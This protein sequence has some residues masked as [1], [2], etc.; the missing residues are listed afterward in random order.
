MN[1]KYTEFLYPSA[2]PPNLP[3]SQHPAQGGRFVTI[4]E[5]VLIHGYH[6]ESIV[7]IQVHSW[8]C[9]FYGFGQ[10]Y[11]DMYPPSQYQIEYFPCSRKPLALPIYPSLSSTSWQPLIFF[12]PL[13]LPFPE[14]PI[15]GI[16]QNVAFSDW[17]PSL[18]N[19][20]LTFLHVFHG[21]LARFSK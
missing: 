7:Y 9:A 12:F 11:N 8:W 19:R 21:L 2:H 15:V 5:A 6:P 17:P 14:C 4:G 10:M 3:H 16:I 1:G 20:H 13:V 18:S